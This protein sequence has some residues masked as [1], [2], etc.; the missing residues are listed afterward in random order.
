M[1][2]TM[3]CVIDWEVPTP[4]TIPFCNPWL[5]DNDAQVQ[6]RWKTASIHELLSAPNIK[7]PEYEL[8]GVN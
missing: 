6:T 1:I 4:E 2:V 7:A 5:F 8:N 3:H